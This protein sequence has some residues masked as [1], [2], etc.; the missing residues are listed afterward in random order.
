MKD[1]IFYP[2]Y[3]LKHP[4]DGFY[5]M[6]HEKRGS[7]AVA[8]IYLFLFWIVYSINKQYAGFVV[9]QINPLTMNTLLD[10]LA[11]VALFVLFATAN[12]SI[13]SLMNGEGKFKEIIMA[14]AYAMTPMILLYIPATILGNYVAKNEETFYFMLISISIVWF[15]I[16][17]F[18]GI[19]TIHAYGL[20]KTIMTFLLTV[21]SMLVIVF[22]LLL[23]VTL[24]QQVLMFVVSIYRE[25][26]FRA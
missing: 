4:F 17:L 3:I 15:L 6:K 14:T 1:K 5:D 19:M 11:I 2:L 25:L 10:L 9:N 22:L 26:I 7:T 12:W 18:I 23:M 24:I 20:L 13:T 16:L 21:I 8:F